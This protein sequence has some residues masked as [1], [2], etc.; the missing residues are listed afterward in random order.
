M[1]TVFLAKLANFRWPG[2][3]VHN[4]CAAWL[5]PSDLLRKINVPVNRNGVP[6]LYDVLWREKVCG[7]RGEVPANAD[8]WSE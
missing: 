3:F 8:L 7:Y 4:D 6:Y 2:R 5:C 1:A